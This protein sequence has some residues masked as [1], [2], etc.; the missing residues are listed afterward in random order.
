MASTHRLQSSS[1][2]GL[3]YRILTMNLKQELLWSLWV[4]AKSPPRDRQRAPRT[5]RSNFCSCIASMYTYSLYAD[6]GQNFG[7]L[8]SFRKELLCR[9]KHLQTTLPI[10]PLHTS[11]ILATSAPLFIKCIF[12][13]FREHSDRN[14]EP[15]N[16]RNPKPS[17]AKS[18]A[19]S[20]AEPVPAK[21]CTSLPSCA[22][23]ALGLGLTVQG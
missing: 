18:T 8:R 2:L 4:E 9:L 6:W 12:S 20:S 14:P 5:D 15:P 17:T 22:S 16:R 13:E 11:H 1:F 10:K 23:R 3:P 21:I 19:A 7:V